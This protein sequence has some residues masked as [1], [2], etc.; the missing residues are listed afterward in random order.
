MNL[1]E[2]YAFVARFDRV[3][4][5]KTKLC[6][7]YG[8]GRSTGYWIKERLKDLEEE[9]LQLDESSFRKPGRPRTVAWEP[10]E[11]LEN[12]IL[13]RDEELV[14]ERKKGFAREFIAMKEVRQMAEAC[15]V[16]YSDATLRR[17]LARIG[18]CTAGQQL[19]RKRIERLGKCDK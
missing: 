3:G 9:G 8:F 15:K 4:V 2:Y 6:A 10:R 18:V 7:D 17:L 11:D 5:N 12:M 16:E 19:H 13:L 14:K 1:E